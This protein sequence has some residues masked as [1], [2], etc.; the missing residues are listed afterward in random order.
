[1][2]SLV[3]ES[4]S[5]ISKYTKEEVSELADNISKEIILGGNPESAWAFLTKI[6]SLCKQVKEQIQQDA[7]SEIDKGNSIVG[8]STLKVIES[9]RYFFKNDKVWNNMNDAIKERENILKSLKE[10]TEFIDE[11]TGEVVI[12]SPAVKTK[13]T[14]IKTDY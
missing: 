14:Y 4:A 5:P 9:N 3:L 1:M 11:E 7:I 6:E 13:I 8:N 2:N 12:L 10:D